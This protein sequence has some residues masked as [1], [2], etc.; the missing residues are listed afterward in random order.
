MDRI[1]SLNVLFRGHH[2]FSG[3]NLYIYTK[4]GMIPMMDITKLNILDL[5]DTTQIPFSY[6]EPLEAQCEHKWVQMSQQTRSADEI[7]T[8]QS[9]C[10]ICSKQQ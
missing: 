6:N 10:I 9:V 2:S 8:I 5:P 3:S 7:V 4:N 1:R